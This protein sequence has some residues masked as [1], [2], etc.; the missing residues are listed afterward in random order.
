MDLIRSQEW[1]S[2]WTFGICKNL[3]QCADWGAT[4][5]IIAG[6][7]AEIGGNMATR[8]EWTALQD[9]LQEGFV[10]TTYCVPRITP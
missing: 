10:S 1:Y 3:E 7:Q 9:D 6:V 5:I 8:K 4:N 2:P